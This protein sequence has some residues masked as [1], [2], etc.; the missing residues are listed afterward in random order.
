M[1]LESFSSRQVDTGQ[2]VLEGLRGL[3]GPMLSCLTTF[4]RSAFPPGKSSEAGGGGGVSCQQT[5]N[6]NDSLFLQS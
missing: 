1:L 4:K 3:G 5:V 2:R 6:I